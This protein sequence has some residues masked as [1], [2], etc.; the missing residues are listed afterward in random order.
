MYLDRTKIL[1]TGW[2][3]DTNASYRVTKVKD[4]AVQKKHLKVDR[5]YFFDDVKLESLLFSNK[6]MNS[7]YSSDFKQQ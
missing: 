4:Q 1:Y 7:P 3:E 2:G 6:I 5:L